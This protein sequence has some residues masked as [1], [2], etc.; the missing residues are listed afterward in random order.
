MPLSNATIRAVSLGAKP[1][2]LFDAGGLYLEVSPA[3][4]KL[5]RWKYRFEGK[6]KR[7]AFG[8]Y[9][10]VGLKAARDKRD[11]ARKL[12]AQGLDPGKEKK[13]KSAARVSPLDKILSRTPRISHRRPPEAMAPGPLAE[14][15]IDDL[16]ESV[17]RFLLSHTLATAVEVARAMGRSLR[18]IQLILDGIECKGLASHSPQIPRRYIAAQPELAIVALVKQRQADMERALLTIPGLKEEA[19]HSAEDDVREQIVE[20]ITSREA[21]GQIF[22]QIQQAMTSDVMVFQ[23]APMLFADDMKKGP[24][25]NIR[26]R[27]ISD[28][29]Y[30]A[31]P[32]SLEALQ[33]ATQLGEQTRFFSA[34]PVKMLIIDR[35]IGLIPLSTENP[36]G[37]CLLLRESALLDALCALFEL[38]WKQSASVA[39]ND[40]GSFHIGDKPP[41]VSEAAAVQIIPLL[42]AG[43]N[44]KAIAHKAGISSNTLTRRIA[45]LMHRFD[46]RTRFQLGWQAALEAFPEG[47]KA[48]SAID[49]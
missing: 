39:F 35:C 36:G 29:S 42:A 14:L 38:I 28:D 40:E 25:S 8:A 46:A 27:T 44:D 7:L 12:L 43:L 23:R 45:E 1:Q 17:Y 30:L 19:S 9:P 48:K 16:E 37:P 34:L 15:G 4:S 31:L 26:V 13:L 2:R 6:E 10:I 24:P 32:G 21:L 3:G 5:W 22:V 11:L 20:V 18:K 47:S 41:R 33:R 49:A